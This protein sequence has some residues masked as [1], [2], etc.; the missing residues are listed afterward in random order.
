MNLLYHF[1]HPGLSIPTN[2]FPSL[3]LVPSQLLVGLAVSVAMRLCTVNDPPQLCLSFFTQLNITRS[4]VL[5][6]SVWFS[7]ARDSDEP[8]SGNPSKSNLCNA[9]SL[10]IGQLLYLLD[11]TASILEIAFAFL[12]VSAEALR[13]PCTF[14]LSSSAKAAI[15]SS[16]S[17]YW[18]Q[19]DANHTKIRRESL[20]SGLYHRYIS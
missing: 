11:N 12:N 5:F 6:Q 3:A 7:S 20:L 8:L 1:T 10:L 13:K 17:K 9:A 19:Y 14:R 15:D 2:H 16:Q 18:D 4:P